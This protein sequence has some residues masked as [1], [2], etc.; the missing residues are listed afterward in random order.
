MIAASLFWDAGGQ[1]HNR[2]ISLTNLA[3]NWNPGKVIRMTSAY[4]KCFQ[5]SLCKPQNAWWIWENIYPKSKI[6]VC[7]KTFVGSY[8]L[9]ENFLAILNPA[10]TRTLRFLKVK[11][12]CKTV[13]IRRIRSTALHCKDTKRV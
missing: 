6:Q 13:R 2:N 11:V 7:W 5:V 3:H 12:F 9:K 8:C 4:S 1:A 10:S